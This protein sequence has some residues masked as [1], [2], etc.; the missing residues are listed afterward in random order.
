MRVDHPTG[1]G[2]PGADLHRAREH[3]F[4]NLNLTEVEVERDKYVDGRT[5][6]ILE[7]APEVRNVLENPIGLSYLG[8]DRVGNILQ[9]SLQDL[10][11][12]RR[13]PNERFQHLP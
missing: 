13:I 10:S 9:F 2:R 12:Q 7:S 3:D 4:R 5:Q 1:S 8:P 11:R 6:L